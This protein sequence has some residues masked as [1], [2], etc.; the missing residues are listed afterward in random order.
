MD[1]DNNSSGGSAAGGGLNF[2]AAVTAIA[3]V[4]AIAGRRLRWLDSAYADVPAVVIS[5]TGAAGDDIAVRL[6]DGSRVE[7]QVKKG[8]SRGDRLWEGLIRLSRGLANDPQLSGVLVVCPASSLT[9]R[10]ALSVDLQRMSDGRFDELKEIT[11]EFLEQLGAAGI[12]ANSVVP[13][14]RVTTLHCL[15]ADGASV[16]TAIATLATVATDADLA[17]SVLYS[18]AHALIERKGSRSSAKLMDLLLAAGV[19]SRASSAAPGIVISDFRRW[20]LEKDRNIY[21]P[22]HSRPLDVNQAWIELD[23]R[24]VESSDVPTDASEALAKYRGATER[25]RNEGNPICAR[26]LSR[27]VRPCVVLG[28]PGMGKSTLLRKLA[29]DHALEGTLVLR[30]PARMVANRMHDSGTPFVDALLEWVCSGFSRTLTLEHMRSAG[31]CLILCDGLDEAG[32]LQLLVTEGLSALR[33]GLPDAVIVVTSRPVGYEPA[34][35][36]GWRH[37]EL[38]PIPSTDVQELVLRQVAL[39]SSLPDKKAGVAFAREQLSANEGA[40]IAARSPLILNLV[41]AMLADG[42]ALARSKAKLYRSL[43]ERLSRTSPRIGDSAQ[44]ETSVLLAF[45]NRAAWELTSRPSL[46]KAALL[47]AC[48]D[49]LVNELGYPPLAGRRLADQCW[50]YWERVGI[51]ES[52]SFQGDEFPIFIH[53]TFA[54]FG[55]ASQLAALPVQESEMQIKSHL[56]HSEWREVLDFA[57]SIGCVDTLV[58]ELLQEPS[59]DVQRALTLAADCDA[60]L[61]LTLQVQLSELA[62]HLISGPIAREAVAAAEAFVDFGLR[63]PVVAAP[64]GASMLLSN[65]PWTRLAALALSTLTPASALML[66][67]VAQ[68]LA[69]VSK[70]GSQVGSL[71]RSSEFGFVIGPTIGRQTDTISLFAVRTALEEHSF[72][73]PT[74]LAPILE[75]GYAGTASGSD[76]VARLIQPKF[77]ELAREF[78][79]KQLGGL[80]FDLDSFPDHYA[81]LF[82][83]LKPLLPGVP[84][85]EMRDATAWQLSGVLSAVHFHSLPASWRWPASLAMDD[86]RV[87][88][89]LRG[90]LDSTG[91]NVAA[92]AQE[93]ADIEHT[94][95]NRGAR[96]SWVAYDFTEVVDIV[97]DWTVGS[98]DVGVLERAVYLPMIWLSL[99]AA[100]L[101]LPR[102]AGDRDSVANWVRRAAMRA[103]GSCLRVVAAM[104]KLLPA[105][106][107]LDLVLARLK[108]N[109]IDDLCHLVD[110]LGPADSSTASEVLSASKAIL[111]SHHASLATSWSN[112]L[113]ESGM[114]DKTEYSTLHEAFEHWRSAEDTHP[115]SSGE[116]VDSPR[117]H[118]LQMMARKPEFERKRLL[119]LVTDARSDVAEFALEELM[120]D[121]AAGNFVDEFLLRVGD[122]TYKPSWLRRA[123]NAD[124]PLSA[125]QVVVVRGMLFAERR[126]LRR[127]ALE[128]LRQDP[129]PPEHDPDLE[130]LLTD[131]DLEIRELARRISSSGAADRGL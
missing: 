90:L 65:Q 87:T 110:V 69:E 107:R 68:L 47:I 12:D 118:L 4:D 129:R 46:T 64:V 3:M 108:E 48:G 34:P 122:G 2:Q 27:F 22:G 13:R 20:A 94:A 21:V 112:W 45:L 28:G 83:A 9:I 123:I 84:S 105:D 75:G 51:V 66:P 14:L 130:R 19:T 128:I 99:I 72:E 71:V 120:A 102:I 125:S 8:L 11:R 106:Q 124:V 111:W 92:L 44:P 39:L 42:S 81:I 31:R 32:P 38:L 77:P 121:L 104:M 26:S 79:K 96:V 50:A 56:G 24:V 35:L 25:N 59:L 10:T 88:E 62:G 114:Q 1:V 7:V 109:L 57:A 41:A 97:P 36:A 17:W 115:K 103:T 30:F 126:A 78:L 113:I 82:A 127:A 52:L 76:E 6:T 60:Q 131:G 98:R 73:L 101:V 74:V 67:A 29:L 5:E 43:V 116:I 49:A 93:V 16:K 85:A 40:Q 95:Q 63:F 119:D 15:D 91:I 54:E 18:E 53:K 33:T 58:G 70:L 37:Y 89:T 80:S 86:H 23:A 61:N 117:N 55:A 100:Q